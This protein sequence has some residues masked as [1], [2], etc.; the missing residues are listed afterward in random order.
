MS[1]RPRSPAAP[2][3]AT[4]AA[5][6]S[7]SPGSSSSP[8]GAGGAS[9][10]ARGVLPLG[11]S[12]SGSRRTRALTLGAV[13]AAHAVAGWGL[14]QVDAVRRAVGQATPIFVEWVTQAPPA[15]PPPAPA[16]PPP[17]KPAPKAPAPP[18]PV[19]TAPP[20]PA[21]APFVAP[22]PPPQPA[23]PAPAEPPAPVAA[24]ALPAPAPAP[25]P[26]P[27]KPV[28]ASAVQYL[29][30]PQPVYPLQ[31]KRL[32]ERGLVVLRVVVDVQGRPKQISVEQSSGFRR[33]DEEALRAMRE[34]RFKPY[35]EDGQPREVSVPAPI[36][37]EM[38]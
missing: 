32:G 19:L 36:N 15:P 30:P 7:P 3:R 25:A 4:S 14:M 23:P 21:P 35:M 13:V 24:P 26:L 10:S 22:P 27:P 18:K 38:E 5:A 37:F 2:S 6:P 34:A 11:Y 16:P 9:V 17:M 8:A 29:R 28:S 20:S 1:S 33:L 12:D 31:S